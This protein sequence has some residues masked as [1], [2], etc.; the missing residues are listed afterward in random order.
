MAQR[1]QPSSSAILQQRKA[2]ML[3]ALMFANNETG[4]LQPITQAV[5]VARK[6]GALVHCDAVQ[7]PGK[8]ALDMRAM[9][10]DSLALSAHKFGGLKGAGALVLRP[11]LD[12]TPDTLGGGQERRRRAGTENVTGIVGFGAAAV[13]V[14]RLL[15]EAARI[16]GL[17][18]TLETGLRAAAPN[19]RIYAETWPRL[20][21]TT[22]LALPGVASET[23][24][25]R[26][27][28]AGIAVSA[29]SA[30]SSGKIAP[31][32]VL[33]AMGVA[34]DEAKSAIRVSLGWENGEK[35]VSRFLAAW[36]PL[37]SSAAA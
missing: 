34:P 5:E 12:L 28:L 37:A 11:G 10:V 18:A 25:M 24:L 8:V 17:R 33:L 26:L 16:A 36:Q 22:C 29:G 2:P 9:G 15:A 31:S 35:D 23:Q 20:P 30:C 4:V 19:A 3:V 6:Y 27:D 7:A 13:A 32:H 21:N 14:P 1:W